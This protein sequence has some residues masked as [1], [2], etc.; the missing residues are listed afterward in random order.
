VPGVFVPERAEQWPDV[1]PMTR[2]RFAAYL[3]TQSNV[4]G[5]P[6]ERVRAWFAAAL[7]PFFPGDEP[8]PVSFRASYQLL[9]RGASG[10]GP[11]AARGVAAAGCEGPAPG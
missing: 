1:V 7:A 4:A 3:A 6:P 5:E 10:P 8:Q 2:R 9:R 11:A